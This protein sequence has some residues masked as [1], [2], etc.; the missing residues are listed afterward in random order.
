MQKTKVSDDLHG[1]FSGPFLSNILVF[2]L[3]VLVEFGDFRDERVVW[4]R[5]AEQRAD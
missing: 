1:E 5:V 2:R 3:V 4:I